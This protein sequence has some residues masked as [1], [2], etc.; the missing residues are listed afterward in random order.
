[1][2]EGEDKTPATD[3]SDACQMSLW[4]IWTTY[5]CTFL[6]RQE[7][8]VLECSLGANLLVHVKLWILDEESDSLPAGA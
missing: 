8:K 4:Q 2:R 6:L 1:M 3:L 7:L 5:E